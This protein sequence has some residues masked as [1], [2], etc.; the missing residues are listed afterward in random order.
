MTVVSVDLL[1]NRYYQSLV[2]TRHL[3]SL[4]GRPGVEGRR[5]VSASRWRAGYDVL[6]PR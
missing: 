1:T 3:E 6:L 2:H 5:E 4:A